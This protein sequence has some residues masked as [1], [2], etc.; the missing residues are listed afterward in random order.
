MNT[1]RHLAI[2]TIATVLV[3]ALLAV[4]F[5]NEQVRMQEETEAQ[6]GQLIARGAHLY[7]DY[8]AGCHGKRGEGIPGIYP[9]LNVDDLWAGR[10]DLAFYGTLHD[11][12]SL[13]ISAGHP[14]QKMPSWADEYGGPL[15]NDQIED[16][17]QFVL[18]WMGPQPEGVR[19]E[20]AAP[21]RTPT[22]AEGPTPAEPSGPVAAGNA[23]KGA[24]IFAANCSTCHGQDAGGGPLGPTLISAEV[25][26]QDDGVYRDAITN[27]RA[28]TAMP[29]WGSILSPQDIEDVIT[30]VRSKQ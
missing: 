12:I 18:N 21:A 24:E 19:P 10:E 6:Q 25:A 14:S 27:G 5:F 22:P 23:V 30:F 11:Y 3:I 17:T 9:P 13:N 7:D 20:V 2:A 4:V 8:C 16:L 15:R 1:V 26:A 29:A 28:G